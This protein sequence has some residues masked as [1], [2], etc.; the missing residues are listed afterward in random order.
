MSSEN[1]KVH[2]FDIYCLHKNGKLQ[3]QAQ[4][5]E[6][7]ESYTI[8][9]MPLQQSAQHMDLYLDELYNLMVT[10]DREYT[11]VQDKVF[12]TRR[13]EFPNNEYVEAT[14]FHHVLM[15]KGSY[16]YVQQKSDRGTRFLLFAM[17]RIHHHSVSLG[18]TMREPIVEEE[19][20]SMQEKLEKL[21]LQNLQKMEV[22]FNMITNKELYFL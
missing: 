4:V 11:Y 21:D 3:K 9:A 17:N 14:I 18:F 10:Y 16:F 5:E 8:K 12:I 13:Y 15:R 1:I 7:K 19:I 20:K 6:T 22:D 2:T